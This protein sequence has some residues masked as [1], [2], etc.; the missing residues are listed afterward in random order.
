MINNKKNIGHNNSS[1]L[2]LTINFDDYLSEFDESNYN[3]SVI[4]DKRNFLET[5]VDS[6]KG[7]HLCVNTFIQDNIRPI[8]MKIVHLLFYMALY[9]LLV[10]YFMMKV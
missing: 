6:I 3:Q 1:T 2:K 7:D 10:V 5:F 8:T 9:F 4:N